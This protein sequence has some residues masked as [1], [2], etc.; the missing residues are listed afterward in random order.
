MDKVVSIVVTAGT[1]KHYLVAEQHLKPILAYMKAYIVP[2]YV[3]IE[4][5]DFLRDE[6]VNDDIS[7]R[8]ARLVEDTVYT[9]EAYA[10]IRE[11]F[12]EQYG[13]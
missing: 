2:T 11:K 7:F 13:F 5:A 1:A 10:M 4:E 3:F 9:V 12:D 8:L 6:I